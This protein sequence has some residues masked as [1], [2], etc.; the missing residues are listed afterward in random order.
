MSI[1]IKDPAT[2][3]AVRELAKLRG[4]SLTEAIREAIEKAL[5]AEAANRVKSRMEKLQ[6]IQDRV[7]QWPD[8]GLKADK[9]FYD[10][11][12]GDT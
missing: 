11:L 5:E 2:D 3:K 8:S 4:V 12:S 10:W 7:A 6:E 9:E 1:Y